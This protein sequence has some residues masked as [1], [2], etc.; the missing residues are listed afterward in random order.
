M[1]I[2]TFTTVALLAQPSVNNM[3]MAVMCRPCRSASMRKP[4]TP[5]IFAS[6]S[7]VQMV[8]YTAHGPDFPNATADQFIT[9]RTPLMLRGRD[10]DLAKSQR[11]L[12]HIACTVYEN[13]R[14]HR[15]FLTLNVSCMGSSSR[16]RM[17]HVY[18]VCASLLL[19]FRN[20]LAVWFCGNA[21]HTHTTKNTIG[22]H[23]QP[24]LWWS[25]AGSRLLP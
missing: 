17:L 6:Y 8:Y 20:I 22:T 2:A 19:R 23:K 15:Y 25:S 5:G 12:Q 9:W 24:L 11:P 14:L 10:L 7:C 18:S 13:S 21:A 4:D 1:K 3:R 16:K